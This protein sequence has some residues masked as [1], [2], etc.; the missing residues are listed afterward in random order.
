MA[1]LAPRWLKRSEYHIGA[2]RPTKI[3]AATN[4]L[5]KQLGGRRRVDRKHHI[6]VR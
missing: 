3:A 2:R 5:A 4:D 1:R 6:R